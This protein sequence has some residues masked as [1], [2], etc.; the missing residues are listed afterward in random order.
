MVVVVV[1]VVVEAMRKRTK[2]ENRMSGARERERMHERLPRHH[3]L[4]LGSF[5]FTRH[6]ACKSGQRQNSRHE[7]LPG[8][9]PVLKR[10]SMKL[11]VEQREW[12]DSN[13]VEDDDN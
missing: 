2:G 7:S 10:R 1:V 4:C 8:Y 3:S 12:R 13:G 5:A 11:I 6:D 9:F